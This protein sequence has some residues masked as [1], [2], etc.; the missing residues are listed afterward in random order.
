MR[1]L[2]LRHLGADPR[3]LAHDT[4]QY[5]QEV[6]VD[7]GIIIGRLAFTLRED[8]VKE[9]E[10]PIKLLQAKHGTR[11]LQILKQN[12]VGYG[13][14]HVQNMQRGVAFFAAVDGVHLLGSQ[15]IDLFLFDRVGV[16]LYIKAAAAAQYAD[17]LK[18][19]MAVRLVFPVLPVLAAP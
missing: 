5:F 19:V 2:G 18:I 3:A 13:E 17:H 7:D 16:I 15:Q 9:P 8:P 11:A 4:H 14:F 6:P 12:G 1:R 10:E